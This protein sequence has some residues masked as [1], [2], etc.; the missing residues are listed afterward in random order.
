M[1][2]NYLL[3]FLL[4]AA[5]TERNGFITLS[6]GNPKGWYCIDLSD[7]RN[8]LWDAFNSSCF[9]NPDQ[10]IQCLDPIP[11]SDVWGIQA[12]SEGVLVTVNGKT[13]FYVCGD[14]VYTSDK[15]ACRELKLKAAGFKGSCGSFRG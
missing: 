12:A 15:G 10:A 9:V 8:I 7:S 11:S 13:D 6:G 14:R 5:A 1:K 3:T 2:L 4:S